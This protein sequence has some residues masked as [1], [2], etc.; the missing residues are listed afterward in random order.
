LTAD[1][2]CSRPKAKWIFA[3]STVVAARLRQEVFCMGLSLHSNANS[4]KIL[5]CDQVPHLQFIET[6]VDFW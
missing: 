3:F 4:L 2:C 5:L 1:C 6:A